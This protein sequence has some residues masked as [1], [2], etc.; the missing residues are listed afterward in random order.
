[1]IEQTTDKTR[2]SCGLVRGIPEGET[3]VPAQW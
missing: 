2:I 3:M 1:M